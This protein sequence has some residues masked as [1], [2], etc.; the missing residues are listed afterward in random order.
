MPRSPYVARLALLVPIL[1]GVVFIGCAKEE[2]TVIA[3]APAPTGDSAAREEAIAKRMAELDKEHP[4]M[5][6]S[7]R[8]TQ[9]SR[10][11]SRSAPNP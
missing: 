10:E 1:Y 3:N 6:K 4:G 2:P 11:L 8:Y 7:M 5:P 9:A